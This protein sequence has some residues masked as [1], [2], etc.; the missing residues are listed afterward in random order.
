M[1]SKYIYGNGE[2]KEEGLYPR[3]E[4]PYC[5]QVNK[6][7]MNNIKITRLIRLDADVHKFMKIKSAKLG[8]PMSYLLSSI[9][10]KHYQN[11]K[12]IKNEKHTKK[13]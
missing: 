4:S 12:E 7:N 9:V 6:Q 5:Q 13:F 8:I 1:R 2:W 3:T 10:K 11:K